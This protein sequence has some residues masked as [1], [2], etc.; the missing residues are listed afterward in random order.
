MEDA[1]GLLTRIRDCIIGKRYKDAV[2]CAEE[3]LRPV[4]RDVLPSELHLAVAQACENIGDFARAQNF[5][6][7][8]A[9]YW[10]ENRNT[11]AALFASARIAAEHL[12]DY[13]GALRH[14]MVIIQKF[15]T[16]EGMENVTELVAS[17]QRTLSRVSAVKDE[18]E[19]DESPRLII[20]QTSDQLPLAQIAKMVA[21]FSKS[22]PLDVTRRLRKTGWIIAWDLEKGPAMALAG[23]LQKAGVPVLVLPSSKM[24]TLPP[25]EK[26]KICA[27]LA[28]SLQVTMKL[29]PKPVLV[30]IPW[31][32]LQ[33]VV[34]GFVQRSV[35]QP[36]TGSNPLEGF[37]TFG[38]FG[39]RGARLHS[40][41]MT[42]AVRAAKVEQLQVIDIV[43]TSGEARYRASDGDTV[44]KYREQ[45]RR[46]FAALARM[47][48]V[49]SGGK[50]RANEAAYLLAG[51]QK[52]RGWK[53]FVFRDFNQFD[54]YV[55]WQ[56]NL[57]KFS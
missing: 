33:M 3:Y 6:R 36:M 4:T 10:P 8:Y 12:N 24:V 31:D 46:D 35:Y 27:P 57:H 16:W 53:E 25:V 50:A 17:I 26:V 28:S 34:A 49:G 52:I 21:F 45:T 43:P 13:D 32:Q 41:D 11:P 1:Q 23:E 54:T 51:R 30:N 39:Y 37:G 9:R 15:P 14:L 2:R 18:D 44:V 5:Y 7:I 29:T 40:V 55:F 20:R 48:L 38:A 42:P 22:T 56:L 19:S 47:L